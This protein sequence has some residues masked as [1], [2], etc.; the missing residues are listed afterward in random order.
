V[1]SSLLYEILEVSAERD[2]LATALISGNH[3]CTYS[4]LRARAET[5]SL[6]LQSAGIGKG[7]R[8]GIYLPKSIEFVEAIFGILRSEAAYLPL[9]FNAP[10]ERNRYIIDNCEAKAIIIHKDKYESFESTYSTVCMLGTELFLIKRNTETEKNKNDLA[11]IL[12]TSGSTGRPK[13]VMISDSAALAFIEWCSSAFELNA[14][15]RFS[16]HAPFHF[17]L[18]VFD[19]F[20]S[21]KH[22]ASLVLI[23]EETAKQPLLLAKM[24]SE[25]KITVWYSTPTILNLLAVYGKMNKYNYDHLRLVLFAGEVFPVG[26]FNNL[27]QQWT[28]PVYYNLY[29]PTETNVCT[30]YRI[31]SDA[32]SFSSSFPIG[33]CCAHF[34]G[35]IFNEDSGSGE[36]LISGKGVMDGYWEAAGSESDAFYI[37]SNDTRWYRTGDLV[38]IDKNNDYVFRGRI[39]RMVKRNGY[40]IELSEIETVLNLDP[41]IN[42]CA[43]I[44]SR[45]NNENTI[46]TAFVCCFASEDESEIKMKEY[47][48]KHLPLYMIPNTFIFLK[49]LPLTPNS[50]TDLQQLKQL[51]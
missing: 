37:D 4:E 8:V 21:L 17:D 26:Q 44:S 47:C 31:P 19:L 51:L 2:P 32:L 45:D 18:S 42:E 10:V 39:D 25:E 24:I 27:K 50:K 35:M 1:D 29:G 20:V 43:V 14:A 6:K 13:G 16:S 9:D 28:R 3:H 49:R 23:D 40:R 7:D 41:V 30:F 12:Y 22:G 33:K 36:L 15:D 38:S 48:T 34:K 5:L 11:Y 46:I